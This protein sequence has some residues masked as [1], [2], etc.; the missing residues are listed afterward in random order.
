M[1]TLGE[2][3]PLLKSEVAT[4]ASGHSKSRA[5]MVAN[6][7]TVK[8][9][10]PGRSSTRA[11]KNASHEPHQQPEFFHPTQPPALAWKGA[12]PQTAFRPHAFQTEQ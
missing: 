10:P 11:H 5:A 2:K 4:G 8:S 12:L 1:V 3:S 7:P 6:K 9:I